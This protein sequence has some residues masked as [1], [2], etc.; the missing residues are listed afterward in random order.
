[1]A[2]KFKG[3]EA[4]IRRSEDGQNFLVTAR[5]KDPQTGELV[6]VELV[7]VPG[8]F[9]DNPNIK[10]PLSPLT[11]RAVLPAGQSPEFS[12]SAITPTP[13]PTP[14]P[15]ATKHPE[16]TPTPENT[17]TPALEPSAN[18]ETS[19]S[20]KEYTLIWN[21]KEFRVAY[22]FP[23]LFEGID[24]ENPTFHYEKLQDVP[25]IPIED[26]QNGIAAQSVL[27]KIQQDG[28][29]PFYDDTVYYWKKNGGFAL[30]FIMTPKNEKF[31]ILKARAN[32]RDTTKGDAP[33]SRKNTAIQ[34]TPYWLKTQIGE[35]AY[36]INALALFDPANPDSPDKR[37]YKIVFGLPIWVGEGESVISLEDLNYDYSAFYKDPKN[38]LLR[39]NN[40]RLYADEAYQANH[41]LLSQLLAIEGNDARV[42]NGFNPDIQ[43]YIDQLS[44]ENRI[45]ESPMTGPGY[46]VPLDKL[47]QQMLFIFEVGVAQ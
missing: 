35:Q 28:Y 16:H 13:E 4:H 15:S 10:N 41:P 46:H 37:E 8:S 5:M 42:L 40:I 18:P 44:S 39:P 23:K 34:I 3:A 21:G 31:V 14:S 36:Y 47:I 33:F 29:Q 11:V 12:A 30:Q 17:I 1:M 19:S 45:M 7:L 27:T 24:T 32:D 43:Y 25:F 38:G 20:F 6:P 9:S 26:I 22:E 2:G